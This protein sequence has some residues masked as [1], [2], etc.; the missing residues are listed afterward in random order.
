M[1]AH[2]SPRIKIYLNGKITGEKYENEPVKKLVRI[3]I[4]Q[5]MKDEP[6]DT[7]TIHQKILASLLPISIQ[8][9]LAA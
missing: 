9:Q 7:R 5:L 4:R 6:V 1:N 2:K 3:L 8:Q